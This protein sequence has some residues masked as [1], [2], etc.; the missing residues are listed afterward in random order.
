MA[1]KSLFSRL[2]KS[3]DKELRD[4]NDRL[5]AAVGE[6]RDLSSYDVKFIEAEAST[7]GPNGMANFAGVD[8]VVDVAALQKVYATETWVYSAVNA[9]SDTISALPIRLEKR[10]EYKRTVFNDLSGQNETITH[11]AWE[12]N[13]GD[14]L[15]RLFERPNKFTTKNEFISLLII[16]LL[17]AGDY[18]VYIDSDQDL[19]ALAIA[20]EHQD[21][22]GG[23][24]DP[25]GRLRTA[26]AVNAHI[27]AM[28]RIPPSM[29]KPVADKETGGLAGYVLQTDRGNFAFDCAEI[30]HVRLPNPNDQYI[31]L[32][33]LIPAFK[34][35]LLDRF[36]TEH[37]VR[38]YKSGARLGGIIT[39]DKA[40]NKEQ[41]GRFQRTF[42]ANYTGRHNHHR[43]LVLPPG[44]KY[45]QVEQNPA[46][47][48]LLDFCRYNREAI[49]AVYRVPPIKLGIMDNANYANA[50][51]QL[52]LFFTQTVKK[53]IDLVQD[54]FNTHP[55]MLLDNRTYRIQFDLSNVE[56]L[57]EDIKEKATAAAEM[58]KA[59]ATVDEV[60]EAVWKKG[61]IDGGNQSPVVVEMEAKKR[62]SQ[63]PL[64]QNLSAPQATETKITTE[65]G[66]GKVE[67][68]EALPD[69][70]EDT[71]RL[72]DVTPTTTTFSERVAQLV[73]AFVAGG[74]PLSI[75]IPKAIEQAKQ[76]GFMD[77][78]DDG[79]DNDGGNKPTQQEQSEPQDTEPTKEMGV[80]AG[81]SGAD[82]VATQVGTEPIKCP[83]CGKPRENCECDGKSTGKPSFAEFLSAEIAKLGD[84]TEVTPE[85]FNDIKAR[86]E[87]LG[88]VKEV[89][90]ANGHT[91]ESV[92][93]HWKNFQSKTDPLIVKH[94][95]LV[96]KF[97][98][99]YKSLVMNRFGANL[100]SFGAF[101]AR[102]NDDADEIL[103]PKA[104]K[105]L[106]DEYIA[107]I[108]KAL[109]E[110]VKEG[111]ADTLVDFDFGAPTE[112]AKQALR[113]YALKSATSIDETTREQLKT[114]LVKMFEDGASVQDIGKAIA[115]KFEEISTGRAQTIARTEVL[116]AVSLGKAA[117]RTEWQERFPDAK[118]MKMWVTAKDDRV[119]DSHVE[120]EG[121]SVP[122]DETF[123]NGLAYPRDPSGEASEV[124]NCR[125]D[126]IDY[127]AQD[128]ELVEG[129]LNSNTDE[130]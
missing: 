18:Y 32:S 48:A 42:E 82:W 106:V 60:R 17:T 51:V 12:A 62:G 122:S 86:Y 39:T 123:A 98:K 115:D 117:K 41:L 74:V 29:I 93:A 103:D 23:K 113:Q 53:Y 38:F 119:R 112:E 57:Q 126:V 3:A 76:E 87:A 114:M 61:P 88:T 26:L 129:A 127:A 77:P 94:Y 49:L 111:Y 81:E 58:L 28:Y 128:Q 10:R 120:L 4:L 84:D 64:F 96:Q 22:N 83:T 116:T 85:M 67:A 13:N 33:P 107:E 99:K 27:K 16:D 52:K 14:K 34:S 121:V 45:E 110:A 56:E 78:E 2:F 90:Y 89:Q 31:G 125:C 50:R 66:E 44:M 7:F 69:A 19:S 68:K 15:S 55:A 9:I 92:T 104:Y 105:K 101:K 102:D 11:E 8:Q 80:E 40:L 43:T 118:L 5:D 6:A 37:M 124:I 100:K 21:E 91:K 73:E 46:E 59:G 20:N 36:S 130:E 1:D 54:G 109:A 97:F 30:I 65:L 72:S 24:D 95:E 35:V 47:T 75:A 25:W 108:D 70:Q 71:A 63:P 79:P